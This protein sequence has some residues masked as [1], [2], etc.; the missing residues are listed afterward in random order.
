MQ[1]VYGLQT[2]CCIGNLWN[3]PVL[4]ATWWDTDTGTILVAFQHCNQVIK[5]QIEES[6]VQ[7]AIPKLNPIIIS[8]C[9]S[10]LSECSFCSS[11]SMAIF[12]SLN[13]GNPLSHF[14][15]SDKWWFFGVK[16]PVFECV[17]LC[18]CLLSWCRERNLSLLD[19]GEKQW[20]CNLMIHFRLWMQPLWCGTKL[21]VPLNGSWFSLWPLTSN[22]LHPTP[23]QQTRLTLFFLYLCRWQNG[24]AD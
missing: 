4:A 3:C 10:L 16:R 11:F 23:D 5:T 13:M 22:Q 12:L 1:N 18:V 6:S 2:W 9:L 17:C 21:S 24:M 7:S 14:T 19:C 15:Q 8:N 20:P